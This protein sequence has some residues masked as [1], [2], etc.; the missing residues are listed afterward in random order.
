MLL[1]SI[2]ICLVLP[3]FP[4]LPP[5]LRL[6]L[7][8]R[9]SLLSRL[10]LSMGRRPWCLHTQ[11]CQDCLRHCLQARRC[12][13]VLPRKLPES[14]PLPLLQR[15]RL[16]QS[17]RMQMERQSR[18]VPQLMR[19]PQQH[20]RPHHSSTQL[21]CRHDMCLHQQHLRR[22]LSFRLLRSQP[23]QL[24]QPLHVGRCNQPMP[25]HLLSPNVR[26]NLP[27][28]WRRNVRMDK[29]QHL[30]EEVRLPLLRR[31][32]HHRRK[33]HCLYSRC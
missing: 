27:T 3:R 14:M 33:L 18:K 4:Q 22:R 12:L 26:L 2:A 31:P 5:Y 28:S 9:R 10:L 32:Q 8:N 11:L 30:Q 20:H 17:S 6:P 13:R 24:Q 15:S 29:L 19:S 25:R 1:C 23:L 16:Q 7:L 21:Y